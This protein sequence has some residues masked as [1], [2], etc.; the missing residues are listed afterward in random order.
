[1]RNKDVAAEAVSIW[2]CVYF[3]HNV[4]NKLIKHDN[5]DIYNVTKIDLK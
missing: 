3:Y 1:M 5:T 2:K 4:Y